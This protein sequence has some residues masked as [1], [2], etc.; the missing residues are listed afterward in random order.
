VYLIPVRS[1]APFMTST[2]AVT[3]RQDGPRVF[4]LALP[5]GRS[6][7]MLRHNPVV[8]NDPGFPLP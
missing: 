3:P 7:V 2:L 5:L 6:A 1:L 8:G 4:Q